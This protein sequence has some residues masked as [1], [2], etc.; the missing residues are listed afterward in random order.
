MRAC[1]GLGQGKAQ[2]NVSGACTRIIQA[3]EGTQ[4]FGMALGLDAWAVIANI[5]PHSVGAA[6]KRYIDRRRAMMQGIADQV[7]EQTRQGHG[8]AING[9][10]GF[11]RYRQR[12]G[13]SRALPCADAPMRPVSHSCR[14]RGLKRYAAGSVPRTKP[15]N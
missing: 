9:K 13:G 5:D 3:G 7:V 11:F 10:Q 12:D 2:V 6:L 4:R 15:M 14:G 8:I 1:D